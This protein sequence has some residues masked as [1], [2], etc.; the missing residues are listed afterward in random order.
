MNAFEVK[1]HF[2]GLNI[3]VMEFDDGIIAY[4]TDFTALSGFGYCLDK[5]AAQAMEHE[6]F[7]D[8]AYERGYRYITSLYYF[9][10]RFDTSTPSDEISAYFSSKLDTFHQKDLSEYSFSVAYKALD[11]QFSMIK[12]TKITQ[13]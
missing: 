6:Q 7:L 3:K 9:G 8:L 2:E 12:M 10:D 5:E 11:D 1:E 4:S 13:E